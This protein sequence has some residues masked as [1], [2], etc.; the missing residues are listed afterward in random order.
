M[1]ASVSPGFPDVLH[2]AQAPADRAGKMGL[3]GWLVGSWDM[4]VTA[5]EPGG[6]KHEGRGEIHAGWVLEGRAIQDVWMIPPRA[7]RQ[8]NPP[9]MPVTG[10]W[11]GTTLRIYDPGIDAWHIVWSDPATQFYAQQIGRADGRDIVQEGRHAS[12]ALLRWRF[13]DIAANSFRWRGEHSADDG[14]NWQ[15]QVDI[16][17]RRTAG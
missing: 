11:Y 2:A 4:D 13:T 10:N 5:F 17:A 7:M 1:I 15:L 14:A 8:N 6:A 16:F 12:G 9:P 3:Y